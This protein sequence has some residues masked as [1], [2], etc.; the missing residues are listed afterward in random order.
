LEETINR[1]KKRKMHFT[2]E[3]NLLGAVTPSPLER[4]GDGG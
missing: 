3:E 1:F 2:M 4:E